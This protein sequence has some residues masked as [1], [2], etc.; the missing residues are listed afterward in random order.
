MKPIRVLQSLASLNRGGAES[1]V[2]EWLRNLDQ[3]RVQF[4]FVVPESEAPFDFE[5]EV[6]GLGARIFR[7]PRFA[8]A[9]LIP[10]VLAWYRLLRKHPEWKIIHAHNTTPA[11]IFLSLARLKGRI[12]VAHCHNKGV[13]SNFKNFVRKALTWPLRYVAAARLAC[14]QEA[15]EWMFGHRRT[16]GILPNAIDTR[17]FEFDEGERERTRRELGLEGRF[18]VGHVGSFREQ[19]NHR[20][21]IEI[22]AELSSRHAK[23]H[24]LLVGD[25]ALR[26]EIE[27]RVEQF[28]LGQ[29]VTF[30][31]AR[32]DTPGLFAA[33]DVFLL[34]SLSE[35]L[36]VVLVESQASGLEAIASSV[37]PSEVAFGSLI[38]FL[39]LEAS[40]A[41]WA[42]AILQVCTAVNRKDGAQL[43]R[44]AG[45]DVQ[46]TVVELQNWYASL[47]AADTT[48][49]Q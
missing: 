11:V 34:P 48:S 26:A 49:S 16:S 42:Q 7:V 38:E 47:L 22:F 28:G 41:Q 33:M 31:G 39:P 19:K 40:D 12:A 5:D 20:R 15:G 1:V 36:G 43:V 27:T 46:G 32:S 17:R 18:V 6:R 24:L 14:S 8:L 25:G 21:L 44:S 10:Y 30:T 37:V 13:A 45:Y 3:E 9:S 35:G 23:A 29:K 2:M 4:D